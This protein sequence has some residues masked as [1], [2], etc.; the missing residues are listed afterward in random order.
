[1][2]IERRRWWCWVGLGWGIPTETKTKEMAA[3]KMQP[4]SPGTLR[5]TYFLELFILPLLYHLGLIQTSSLS[6]MVPGHVLTLWHYS[7]EVCCPPWSFRCHFVVSHKS[8]PSNFCVG[9]HCS[10]SKQQPLSEHMRLSHHNA[11]LHM[12][13]FV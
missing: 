10:N 5:T 6:R 13:S 8:K 3:C 2:G 4:P 9:D 7:H 12:Q 11:Y 1:M